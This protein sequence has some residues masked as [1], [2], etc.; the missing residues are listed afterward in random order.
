MKRFSIFL[1]LLAVAGVA[2]ADTVSCSQ[3][4]AP[5]VLLNNFSCTLGGLTFQNFSAVNGGGVP[6]PQVNLVATSH[7][8]NDGTVYLDLNP[9]LS[10]PPGQAVDL[11]LLFQV[12]GGIDQINL[13]VGGEPGTSVITEIA[14]AAQPNGTICPQGTF[15]GA[16]TAASQQATHYSALFPNTSPVF[17][18]KDINVYSPNANTFGQLSFF[19]Q[20]FHTQVPEPGSMVLLS[21]GLLAIG[22]MV[23]RRMF[24]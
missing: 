8:G 4:S 18:T 1:V 24:K 20:S 5:N 16:A 19:E 9:N 11:L 7:V 15:L 2:S 14:C 12:I 17:I 21:S 10:A 3:P 23:R 22:G 6:N 13:T